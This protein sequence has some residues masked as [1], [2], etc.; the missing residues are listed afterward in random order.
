MKIFIGLLAVLAVPLASYCATINVPNDYAT[1]QAAI[2]AA[3]TGDVVLVA[4]GTYVENLDFRG[5]AITVKGSDGPEETLIDGG[6]PS[7]PD[8]GTVVTFVSNEG[9]D[10]VLQGFTLTNG[11]GTFTKAYYYEQYHGG[12]ILCIASSP[13][14]KDIIFDRNNIVHSGMGHCHG[15]GM[16]THDGSTPL[17]VDCA[18]QENFATKSG[19][20]MANFDSSPTVMDCTF[21]ENRATDLGSGGGMYNH[22][23][24]PTVTGCLFSENYALGSSASGGGMYNYQYSSPTVT[25]CIFSGNSASFHGGALLNNVSFVILSGCEFTANYT[26][27]SGGAM[28]NIVSSI[29]LTDC[30]FTNN[31]LN[32]Y[33]GKGGGMS[34]DRTT[35]TLTRCTFTGNCATTTMGM[36]GGMHNDDSHANL[37][38]CAFFGNEATYCGGMYNTG[39]FLKLTGC[40][41]SGN[42]SDYCGGGMYNREGS[43]PYLNSCTFRENV[44]EFDLGG[45]MYSIDSSPMIVN[46]LFAGNTAT[47]G[48][49][50]ACLGSTAELINCL[51]TDNTAAEGGGVHDDD[52]SVLMVNCTFTR[53][54]AAVDGGGI[55]HV[56]GGSQTLINCILWNDRIIPGIPNEISG[57]GSAPLVTYSNVEGGYAGQGNIN[58]DPVFADQAFGCAHLC[59]TS[60]CRDMGDN[61]V[62][63]KYIDFE[64]D[65]R[66]TYGT[67]DMGADEFHTHLYCTGDP[68][69]GGSIKGKLVG[70][71]GSVPVDLFLASGVAN[72]SFHT[73]WGPFYLEAPWIM[74]SIPLPIPASGIMELPATLP[75][76]VPAPYDIFMQALIGKEPDSLTNLYVLEVR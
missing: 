15:G 59:Y 68:A 46:T 36:G 48:G 10:S 1:I 71:P 64:G 65:P 27:E 13:V 40:T 3:S 21:L 28:R 19:G 63:T 74:V 2:N 57:T 7:N 8:F 54:K 33:I 45:G 17:V 30:T 39:S 70:L 75:A 43:S 12:G 47:G 31:R 69:P 42:R 51:I 38:D 34:N 67:V 16:C 41:I 14:I 20:G 24:N 58:V 50:I 32:S 49:G 6:S 55:F 29:T 23:A 37:T 26:N 9:P 18:F 5:K 61:S 11:T 56:N 35:L 73:Q 76:S 44:V 62:V 22:G 4:K 25:D 66:I 53:N 72:Q 60:P 52:S